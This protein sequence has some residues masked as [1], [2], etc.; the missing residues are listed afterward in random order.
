MTSTPFHDLDAYL[1]LPRVSGL[2]V[3][4]DGTR[5]VTTIAELNDERTEF[6]SALW[7]LDPAGQRPAR[8]LTRGAKG[9]AAPTFRSDGDLL[10]IA[11]RPGADK[12]ADKTA[13]LW[14]LPAAGGEA[15]E[16]LALVG[17]VDG[18]RAARN[19]DVTVAAAGLLASAL[20]VADDTRL[21]ALRKETKVSAVLHTNYPVRHWDHD[22]GP[23]QPHLLC[24]S[25]AG[26]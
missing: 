1:D 2:A 6:V 3:S 18:V 9:E 4:P 5:V 23:A 24:S 19:A 10:F 16:E 7:E 21:R 13:S 26:A 25:G 14:R 17:G 22:L 12:D 11:T 8:R 20:D 15:T